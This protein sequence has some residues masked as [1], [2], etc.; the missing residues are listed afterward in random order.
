ME[1]FRLLDRYGMCEVY[2]SSSDLQQKRIEVD[3][4]KYR[5]LD[6]DHVK[7]G[8]IKFKDG[9]R[10]KVL[11]YIPNIHCSSCLYLL[12]N[13]Y[14]FHSGILK[15]N[16]HFPRKELEVDFDHDQISLRKVVQLLASVGYEPYLSLDDLN[17]NNKMSKPRRS[18]LA[19]LGVA[20]FA[21]GNIMLLSFPEYLGATPDVE[22]NLE[23]WFRYLALVLSV[24]VVFYSAWPF[25]ISAWKSLKVGI[26]NVDAPI[27]LAVGVTFIRSAA[28][29]MI[30]GSPGYFD[31][32]SGIVL[33]MLIGR[34]VQDR[35]YD[36]LH[37]ERDYKSYF[38]LSVFVREGEGLSPKPLDTLEKGDLI[39]LKYGDLVPADGILVR[40][41]ACL[42]Y[43]FVTG[44]SELME[45]T[46][47][48]TVYAGARHMGDVIELELLKEVSH[49][50]L[51]SLW[52]KDIFKRE[53]NR[54]DAWLDGVSHIFTWIVI[55]IALGT[56]F[57]WWVVDPGM[58]WDTVTAVL[59]IACP[60][61]LLLAASFTN[62]FVL[63]VFQKFGLYLKSA[64]FL[65]VLSN[66]DVIV[67]D[68]TGTLTNTESFEV[69]QK[70]SRLNG[71][72][73]RVLG[74]ATARSSHPLSAAISTFLGSQDEKALFEVYREIPG[75]GIEAR[76]EGMEIRIGSASFCG[77]QDEK[78]SNDSTVYFSFDQG[79]KK[80]WFEIKQQF[81]PGLKSL[82][83]NL[84]QR[85][86]LKVISGDNNRDEA[87]LKRILGL[88]DEVYFDHLP[89]MKLE[90]IESLQQNGK[91]VIMIGDGLND[92]GALRQS[93]LGIA[94]GYSKKAF[95]PS[96]DAILMEDKVVLIDRFILMAKRG[97][98][99]IAFCFAYSLIY[100]IIGLY[101]AISGQ[102]SPLLA[103]I[104][105][106]ASSLSIIG[107]SYLSIWVLGKRIF[108]KAY[109]VQEQ[110]DNNHLKS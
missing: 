12:E 78:I 88:S 49:S 25:F 7:E 102:L 23:L 66:P 57:Y 110:S 30:N 50:Y 17:K 98:E 92:A 58:I 29:V 15:T 70:G 87:R 72:E 81:R 24:P 28:E 35:T 16:L 84:R 43:S 55:A 26:L 34:Y 1:V 10:S 27:A 32:M 93:D 89:E 39:V 64:T 46:V 97:R 59:I 75:S 106:P 51:T 9:S 18:T 20:A 40:G 107:L 48:Q 65:E 76:F 71:E 63:Q 62:G 11:L 79:R 67:W 60:C 33:F 104:I 105:M 95:T 8:L 69:S 61:T 94:L 99:V 73:L 53:K 13:L 85:I 86:Q 42:D 100:N 74:T 47:G 19:R 14:R 80:G 109:L 5:Y 101:F 22:Q 96:S 108:D 37:F 38:P 41:T 83:A 6:L 77:L 56:A 44:E 4:D 2:Y 68:K 54:R 52:N 91:R 31:S 3:S 45:K 21:F 36:W 90:M 103:A 82:F